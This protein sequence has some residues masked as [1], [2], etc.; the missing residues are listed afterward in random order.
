MS[1]C[2]PGDEAGT[3]NEE[4]LRSSRTLRSHLRQ[5]DLPVPDI[6]YGGRPQ[7]TELTTPITAGPVP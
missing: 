2:A 7:G 4:L 5:T 3:S 1:C 6:L